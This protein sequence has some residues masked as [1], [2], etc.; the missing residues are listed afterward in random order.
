MQ[1]YR[2][3]HRCCQAPTRSVSRH[4]LFRTPTAVRRS[5]A[6][7]AT[8]KKWKGLTEWL[9]NEEPHIIE[10]ELHTWQGGFREYWTACRGKH[11]GPWQAEIQEK[12]EES[13]KARAEKRPPQYI[14]SYLEVQRWPVGLSLAGMGW[15]G[16]RPHVA[17]VFNGEPWC[18]WMTVCSRTEVHTGPADSE[19][20]I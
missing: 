20:Q 1:L 8:P 3:H 10:L 16:R 12:R 15:D 4:P 17:V 2:S 13:D 19:Q 5:H 14:P 6:A 11:W 18:G 7:S 9:V